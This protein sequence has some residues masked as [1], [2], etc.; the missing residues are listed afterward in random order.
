M[1]AGKIFATAV[2]ASV[3]LLNATSIAAKTATVAV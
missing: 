1:K 3:A 2:L